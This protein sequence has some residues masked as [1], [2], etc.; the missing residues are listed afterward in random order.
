MKH[1][2]IFRPVLTFGSEYW[3]MTK[4]QKN[5]MQAI[6]MKYH[7][8]ALGITKKDHKRNDDLR[9]ELGIESI[10]TTIEKN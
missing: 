1:Q 7:R 2:T 5:K 9:E 4:R 8:R 10:T 6:E 3:V